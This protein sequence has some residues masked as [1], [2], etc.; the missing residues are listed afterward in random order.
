MLTRGELV[1]GQTIPYAFGLIHGEHKGL[2]TVSHA[3]GMLGFRTEMVRFPEERFSVIC[4]ANLDAINARG[5]ALQVADLYLADRFSPDAPAQCSYLEL[6]PEALEEYAGVYR[7]PTSGLTVELF[8]QDGGLVVEAGGRSFAL[9]PLSEARFRAADALV[10]LELQFVRQGGGGRYVAQ[11]Q[12]PGR[13]TAQ[14]EP[15]A[16]ATPSAE[17]LSEYVGSYLS[18]ELQTLYEITLDAKEGRLNARR[19]RA[20]I[21]TLKPGSRDIFRLPFA[22][23][24]FN[25]DDGGVVKG[26]TVCSGRVR[27]IDLI[28]K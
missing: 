6:S 12:L 26:C 8:V 13:D 28:R 20:P 14:L 23:L 4:L 18:D 5:L 21:E 7:G 27:G 3:G 11:I 1:S 22:T 9:S 16:V 2:K 17:E 19:G 25:R 15:M 24:H 10:D